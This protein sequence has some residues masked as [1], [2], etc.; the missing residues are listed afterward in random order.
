[1]FLKIDSRLTIYNMSHYCKQ[2]A[3]LLKPT[4]FW[5]KPTIL[6]IKLVDY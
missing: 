4:I 2:F 6:E 1:M 5:K 3:M